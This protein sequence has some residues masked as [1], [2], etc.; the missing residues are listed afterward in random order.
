[1]TL[2]IGLLYVG[3]VLF[4]NGVLRLSKVD[5]KS[6]AI[7]NFF[8]G[9]LLAVI[10]AINIANVVFAG[11]LDA[12]LIDYT[13][14]YGMATNMLF[15]FTYLFVGCTNWFGLDGRPLGWYCFFVACNT[16]PIF[17]ISF[18]GGTPSDIVW[19]II[20]V[21]WGLLW[22]AFWVNGVLGKLSETFMGS[23]TWIAGVITCW[24]PGLL[25]VLG[26]WPFA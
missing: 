26:W 1:M 10:N 6:C 9:G 12:L 18:A 21:I 20:W 19:G 5:G 13:S 8:T 24:I 3:C 11:G 25:M 22:L 17:L 2:G 23:F 15:G 7:M 16:V 14:F 4:M